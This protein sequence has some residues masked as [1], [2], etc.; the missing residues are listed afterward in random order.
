MT[1]YDPIRQEQDDL[2]IARA[3]AIWERAVAFLR[4][5]LK[6]I[7][8]EIRQKIDLDP[9]NWIAPYHFG[10]GMA[11]RNLLRTSGLG[12]KEFGVQNLDNIYVALVE[13]AAQE[14]SPLQQS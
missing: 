2:R 1:P 7:L 5:D 9:Q 6:L 4:L 3:S 11:V 12:E 14:V 8:P 10:W 13:D